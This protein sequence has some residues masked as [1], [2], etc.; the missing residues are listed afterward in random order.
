MATLHVRNIPDEMYQAIRTLAS[1]ERRSISAEVVILLEM[2]LE[3]EDL[4]GR[5]LAA[6][7]SIARQRNSL[8]VPE[9]AVDSLTL[10]REDRDR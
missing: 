6:L 4:R 1:Q 8:D 7:E 2:A 9:G 3:Q 10:L 5:K